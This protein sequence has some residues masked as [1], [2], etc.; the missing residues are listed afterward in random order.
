MLPAPELDHMILSFCSE[1]WQ[2]VARIVGKTFE[3]LEQRG[4]S[5]DGAADKVDERMAALVGSGRLEAKGNIKR[6]G[7][8]EVRLPGGEAAAPVAL[9][10]GNEQA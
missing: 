5:I 1:H 10:G 7:Y 6:W 2:K 3:A 4:I 8:S 9:T